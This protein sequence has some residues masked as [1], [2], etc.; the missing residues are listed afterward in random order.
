[1]FLILEIFLKIYCI[2]QYQHMKKDLQN[3]ASYFKQSTIK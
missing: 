2:E 1:M 3:I